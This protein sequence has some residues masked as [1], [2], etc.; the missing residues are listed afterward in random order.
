MKYVMIDEVF[1]ILFSEK[2][3]H[4]SFKNFGRITSAGSVK[5]II[6]EGK[7]KIETFGYSLT[8]KKVPAERDASLIEKQLS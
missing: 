2:F 7:R 3:S 1:P 4:D 5:I 8:L 6:S